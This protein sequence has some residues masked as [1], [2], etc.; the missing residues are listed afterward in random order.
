MMKTVL[1]KAGTIGTVLAAVI[2]LS[3]GVAHA[4]PAPSGGPII[5]ATSGPVVVIETNVR[6]THDVDCG[7]SFLVFGSSVTMD[8][9]G[10]TVH[11]AGISGIAEETNTLLDVTF[12]SG[13]LVLTGGTGPFRD[14]GQLHFTRM[15]VSGGLFVN[16]SVSLQR[17]FVDGG[18]GIQ[19]AQSLGVTVSD[20]TV[21][22]DITTS[23]GAVTLHRSRIAGSVRAF[24][25]DFG[26]ALSITQNLIGGSVVVDIVAAFPPGDVQGDISHNIVWGG[27]IS[28]VGELVS[29]GPTTVTGNVVIGGPA[30]GITIGG[31][32]N[33]IP[34]NLSGP[35][36]LTGNIA[37]HNAGHGI[38]A[39]W[40]PGQVSRIVDGGHNL[41]LLNGADPQ[42]IGV[43][44]HPV[45]HDH[46][47]R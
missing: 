25:D 5:C 22:G 17:S 39:E 8:F 41:A 16:G 15:G 4:D 32:D 47:D 30:S 37:V 45:F 26:L 3:A 46:E 12:T 10:H 33:R 20:S 18:I 2:C 23:G 21:R 28:I 9:A 43:A 29:L 31:F 36:T 14:T 19:A 27:G 44:C 7:S 35:V 13:R 1:T 6:L 11:A 42:C 40:V 38:D 34:A 24:N